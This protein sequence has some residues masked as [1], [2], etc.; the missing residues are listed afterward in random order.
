MYSP[1]STC[2]LPNVPTYMPY[3]VAP[4]KCC[5]VSSTRNG[6]PFFSSSYIYVYLLFVHTK[7]VSVN[8]SVSVSVG[9]SMTLSDSLL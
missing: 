6:E 5:I 3:V 1:S 2:V 7:R 4:T 8:A 9:L